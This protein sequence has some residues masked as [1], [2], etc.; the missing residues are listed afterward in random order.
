MV[1]PVSMKWLIPCLMILFLGCKK[2]N[3]YETQYYVKYVADG[4]SSIQQAKSN[5]LKIF[6]DN[7]NGTVTEFVRSNRGI[8]E[9]TIGPVKKGFISRVAVTNICPPLDC[10]IRPLLQIH[11]SQD[12][13]PFV[14]KKEFISSQYSDNASITYT[15]Q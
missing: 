10:Y 9:F 4:Q 14:I 11:I 6:I 12:N 1:K 5:G 15:I 13:G 8:N 3:N 7:E 2:S